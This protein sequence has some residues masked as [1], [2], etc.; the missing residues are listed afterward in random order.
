MTTRRTTFNS[1]TAGLDQVTGVTMRSGQEISFREPGAS[2]TNDSMYAVGARGQVVLPSDSVAL[3]WSRK[4]STGR[5]VGL[6]AGVALAGAVI[7]SAIAAGES[8]KMFN[9]TKWYR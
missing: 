4:T 8:F 1:G 3:V 5:T 6:V 7:A 2:V 9:G